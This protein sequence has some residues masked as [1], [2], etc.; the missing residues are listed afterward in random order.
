MVVNRFA[1]L[2]KLKEDNSISQCQNLKLKPTVKKLKSKVQLA[3]KKVMIIGDG[4]ARGCA[5]NL[6]H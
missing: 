1:V 6:I 5:A 2:D 3:K 4:H